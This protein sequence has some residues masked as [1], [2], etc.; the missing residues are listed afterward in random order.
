MDQRTIKEVSKIEKIYAKGRRREY[1]IRNQLLKEGFDIVQ[2]SA[3][4]H[5]PIDIFAISK[6]DRKI[7]FVQVKPDHFVESAKKNLLNQLNYLNNG[8]WEVEFV[9]R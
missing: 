5:S 6:I 7:L 2:R 9:I 1:K 8:N 4:S 3:G